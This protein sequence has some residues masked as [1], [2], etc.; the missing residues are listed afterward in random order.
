[1]L[2]G[3]PSG[4]LQ[5]TLILSCAFAMHHTNNY[6]WFWGVIATTIPLIGSILLLCLPQSASWG[7][8]IS[9]WLAA[10]STDLILVSLSFI[11]SNIKGNTKK[12]TVSALYFIGYSAGCIIG[13]QLWQSEYAPRYNKGC[14]SSIV[15]WVL[16]YASIMAYH[17]SCKR[18]NKRR[19]G[20]AP[21]HAQ[22]EGGTGVA[23]QSDHTDTEDL[24]FR[25][26]L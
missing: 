7:I 20:I 24:K 12:S 9:T 6:R 4:A 1:M 22:F 10:Q 14:I 17:F 19:E 3:L 11:A 8:V 25:Y 21:D 15:S 2:V 13:P 16:L 5:V 26:A 18:E 23:L